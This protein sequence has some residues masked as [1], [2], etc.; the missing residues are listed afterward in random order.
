MKR[1]K[2][3]AALADLALAT[4]AEVKGE[5]GDRFNTSRR[6]M[7]PGRRVPEVPKPETPPEPK[8]DPAVQALAESVDASAK[9]NLLMLAELK[10]QVEAAQSVATT[11]Q[12]IITAWDFTMTRDDKGYLTGV[13]AE[14]YS[15]GQPL[16]T[17][18][19]N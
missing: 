1:V 6:Q 3:D 2:D 10:S 14:A 15:Y 16:N 8:S 18:T 9:A 19:R 13:R 12:T 4:G 7:R 5:G 11:E 17:Q